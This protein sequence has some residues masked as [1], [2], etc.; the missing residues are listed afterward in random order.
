MDVAPAKTPRIPALDMARTLALAAMAVFHFTVDLELFGL[1][2]PGTT[3]AGGWAVAARAIAGSFLF[4][5]GVSLWL[6]HGQ[7]IRWRA[8]L[9]RLAWIVAAAAAV[10][11]GTWLAMP[12]VFVY[13]GILHS[14]ALCSVLGLAFLRLPAGVTLAAALVVLALPLLWRSPALDAPWLLWLGLG[15][16]L[17]PTLDYEPVFPWLAPFLAG[18]ACARLAGRAGLW[19]LLAGRGGRLAG[20]LGWPGRH[21]LAV[22]LI[23]QPVLI[24][25]L[26]AAL[27]LR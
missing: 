8:F 13:F 10:S 17:R 20:A 23:H 14:I 2:A 15:T 7:G 24:A 18:L 26:W 5:A 3:T 9:R 6:A 21:S 12:Q 19:A 1:I 22:Y 4:L 25:L 16:E 11:L 27:H